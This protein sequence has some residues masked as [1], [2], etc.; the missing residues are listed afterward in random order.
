VRL[1]YE[2]SPERSTLRQLAE[3][4]GLSRSTIFK[5]A[6]REHWKQNATLVDA[7]RQQIVKMEATIEAK[8]AEAAELAANQVVADLQPWIEQEF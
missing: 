2:T 1:E 8:T 7:A 5:R 6:A 3:K 4:Y